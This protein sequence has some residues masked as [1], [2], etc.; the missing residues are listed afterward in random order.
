MEMKLAA[1]TPK[2]PFTDRPHRK[3]RAV[4][5]FCIMFLIA[6]VILRIFVWP[7]LWLIL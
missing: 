2:R 5:T 4:L 7:V 3:L 6:A 1:A